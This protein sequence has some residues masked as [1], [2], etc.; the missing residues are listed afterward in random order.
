MRSAML[1]RVIMQDRANNTSIAGVSPGTDEG[2]FSP[3]GVRQHVGVVQA[4]PKLAEL[5]RASS[6]SKL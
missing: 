2:G 1:A 3:V 6:A 4:V 5:G